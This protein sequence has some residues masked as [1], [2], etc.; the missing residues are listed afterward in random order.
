MYIATKFPMTKDW[1]ML[2]YT[3]S[4]EQELD[5]GKVYLYSLCQ[6]LS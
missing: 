3:L 2:S 5:K 4:F 6:Q 1:T